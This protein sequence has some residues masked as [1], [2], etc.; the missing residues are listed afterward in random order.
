MLALFTGDY[1]L[2]YMVRAALLLTPLWASFK[3]AL[4]RPLAPILLSFIFFPPRVQILANPT[5]CP[6]R[7]QKK[8]PLTCGDAKL[9]F[10][11]ALSR[12]GVSGALP[13]YW[14]RWLSF[15]AANVS[16]RVCI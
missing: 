11:M 2:S 8:P 6:L 15:V 14:S 9:S 12:K 5:A 16:V 3:T 1:R 7:S 4:Y 13:R 10:T